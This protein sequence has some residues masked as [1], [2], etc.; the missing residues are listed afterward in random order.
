MSMTQKNANCTIHAPTLRCKGLLWRALCGRLG[1][2]CSKMEMKP[3]GSGGCFDEAEAPQK[4]GVLE[5]FTV[6][7]TFPPMINFMN[8]SSA[9]LKPPPSKGI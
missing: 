8:L 6:R 7:S 4:R 2:L 9:L 5:P 1:D 3:E